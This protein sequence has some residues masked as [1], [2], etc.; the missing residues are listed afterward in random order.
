MCMDLSLS[1]IITSSPKV[2]LTVS[3]TLAI[4]CSL[5]ELCWQST[6]LAEADCNLEID[7]QITARPLAV[8]TCS[9][10]YLN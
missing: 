6:L 5:Y 3:R 4:I 10:K 9:N 7:L 8:A 1:L 2:T